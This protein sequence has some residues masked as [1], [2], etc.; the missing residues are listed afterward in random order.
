MMRR[1]RFR[2]MLTEALLKETLQRF[3]GF[4]LVVAGFRLLWV[5]YSLLIVVVASLVLRS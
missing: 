4:D 5:F 3:S 1:P 2:L